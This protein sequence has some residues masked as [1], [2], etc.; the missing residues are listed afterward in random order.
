M[1]LLITC[2]FVIIL[3]ATMA[4]VSRCLAKYTW[5][6][7]PINTKLLSLSKMSANLKVVDGPFARMEQL[8]FGGG[9]VV[10]DFRIVG[11]G[12]GAFDGDLRVDGSDGFGFDEVLGA[13]L[14]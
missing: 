4:L 6:Y 13:R 14:G 8:A 7:L 12:V 10:K 2:L 1:S 5:P 11:D 9:S 3:I